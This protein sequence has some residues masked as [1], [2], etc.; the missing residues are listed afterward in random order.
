MP[1]INEQPAWEYP[2]PTD[3]EGASK[4]SCDVRWRPW[5]CSPCSKGATPLDFLRRCQEASGRFPKGGWNKVVGLLQKREA[6]WLSDW[7][8]KCSHSDETSILLPELARGSEHA[9]YLDERSGTVTKV[10]LPGC[11]GDFNYLQ[12]C[13]P[14]QAESTPLLYLNRLSIW[15]N[16]FG[17]APT[18][19]GITLDQRIVTKQKFIKGERPTQNEVDDYLLNNGMIPIRQDCYLWKSPRFKN[20]SEAWIGD[21]R[22]ENFVKSEGTIV[23]IDIR[24][25]WKTLNQPARGIPNYTPHPRRR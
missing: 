8:E 21:T 22:D 7:V 2:V 14:C 13:R 11:F 6:K 5:P 15:R 17:N 16:I 12:G 1:T 10:T 3:L 23:P 25:W 20:F 9:V 4:H 19:I 18:P 24:V